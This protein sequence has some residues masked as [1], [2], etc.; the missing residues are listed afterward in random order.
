MGRTCSR[1]AWMVRPPLP[2]FFLR[3][4]TKIL[5]ITFS[6]K[7]ATGLERFSNV[8]LRWEGGDFYIFDW[9]RTLEGKKEGTRRGS[10]PKILSNAADFMSR[11]RSVWLQGGQ[12]QV[13]ILT[14][15][16]LILPST[17]S[18]RATHVYKNSLKFWWC[19]QSGQWG[20]QVWVRNTDA[21][22]N[23]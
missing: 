12:I 22:R 23:G 6:R 21:L 19:R 18:T 17:C 13:N 20:R 8:L 16:A 2:L 4:K 5:M 11:E 14:Q 7:M 3:D 15:L 9:L 10:N 1:L